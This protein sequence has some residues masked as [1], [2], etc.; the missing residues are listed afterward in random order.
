M[1]TTAART[2]LGTKLYKARKARELTQE[3]V[4]KALD[5]DETEISLW[6]R[7]HR[8]PDIPRFQQLCHFYKLDG[9]RMLVLAAKQMN[10][11]KKA[12][13]EVTAT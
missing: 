4:A 6:E 3:Q 10:A 7:G 12:K 9:G 11:A 2:A 1:E 13:G 8:V 5:C